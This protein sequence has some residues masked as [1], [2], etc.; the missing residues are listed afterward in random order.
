MSESSFCFHGHFY[1]PPRGNAL[2]ID[3]TL[4]EPEAAPYRN[5]NERITAECYAPLAA[6]GTFGLM[7]FNVGATLMRWLEA[8]TPETYQRIVA[9][10]HPAFR[11]G[12]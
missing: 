12:R 10:D 1:Q 6:S 9:A 5:W 8:N 4:E 11:P 2:E 7:S 3:G